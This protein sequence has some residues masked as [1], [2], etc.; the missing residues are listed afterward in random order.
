MVFW[1]EFGEGGR[2][3]F[4]YG[5]LCIIEYWLGISLLGGF[6]SP[7][8]FRSFSFFFVLFREGRF[9][10]LYFFSCFLPFSFLSL[11]LFLFFS[12][13]SLFLMKTTSD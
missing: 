2:R 7:F 4:V 3:G 5:F 1:G 8:L 12:A 10:S 13:S 9:V 6:F 11:S